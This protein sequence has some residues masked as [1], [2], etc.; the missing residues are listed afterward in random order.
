[1]KVGDWV[2]VRS[3]EEIL[4]TLDDKGQLDSMPF[5]PEMFAYC[6]KRFQ[7]YKSAHK[8]CDTVFPVRGRWVDRAVH[9]GTRCNGQGHS[10]CQASCVI[11]WKEAWL[12]PVGSGSSRES[13]GSRARERSRGCT[14]ADVWANAQAGAADANGPTYVCQAT[15]L[16]YAT[17]DLKWWDLRQ[18][19]LDYVS[20]NVGIRRML[21]GLVYSLF[22]SLS[23]AGLG[24]G[25]PLRWLYDASSRLRGGSRFPRTCGTIPARQA[26]PTASLD[27]QPGEWVRVKSHQ[28]I[29]QTITTENKNRGMYWDA[30]LVPYCG[31]TYRVLKRVTRIIDERTGKMI[32]LTNPCLILD[33]VVCQARYS[34]QRMFCPRAIYP[35]WREIWLD[36]VQSRA[37][38]PATASRSVR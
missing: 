10:D 19:A 6:G 21:H 34:S 5:M 11:F 15:R 18:Y 13:G 35:Y 33:S 32:D 14:E 22:Y 8:T 20:G 25:R 24:L 17:R 27:L 28:E 9:L 3:K 36:R 37:P 23:Q 12:K 29:L 30:E 26:T 31:G 1:M 16:P 2:E 38:D 4:A 7:V